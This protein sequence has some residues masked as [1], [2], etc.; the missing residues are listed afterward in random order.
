MRLLY[1]MVLLTFTWH[2]TFLYLRTGKLERLTMKY[3]SVAEYAQAVGRTPQA[4]RLRIA[5]G[6]MPSAVR[7]GCQ[8]AI[9]EH[10]VPRERPANRRQTAH[11]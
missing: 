9:P 6:R 2:Y 10:E 3:M 4:I 11:R 8:W 7:I 1:F 5:K